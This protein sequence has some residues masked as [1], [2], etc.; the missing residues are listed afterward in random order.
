MS[1][2]NQL[3]SFLTAVSEVTFSDRIWLLRSSYVWYPLDQLEAE[4][5]LVF[6]A[7]GGIVL[8]SPSGAD[9]VLVDE[10]KIKSLY[11]K[12]LH[13]SANRDESISSVVVEPM[14]F[15]HKCI[16]NGTFSHILPERVGMGGR[17]PGARCVF[18]LSVEH[19]LWLKSEI[20]KACRV[21]S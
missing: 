14:N 6:Q 10:T 15:V 18:F 21:Y 17:A 3:V 20:Q 13:Y 16:D 9:T 11:F 12:Q 2:T 8:D 5:N 19:G 7:R 4:L 1:P